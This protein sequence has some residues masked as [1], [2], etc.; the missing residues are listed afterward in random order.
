M[1]HVAAG[2]VGEGET[3]SRIAPG[4]V[5]LHRVLQAAGLP[6]DGHC[7]V[8]HGDHLAQAAGLALG[9]HQEQ[10]SAGVNGHG[11]RLVV[12]QAHR[13]PSLILLGGPAEKVLV[14]LIA[15][16][17]DHQLHGELHHIMKDLTNQVQSFV[18]HQTA[19][20]GHDGHIGLLPQ[21]HQLLQLRLVRLLAGH[22]L[23]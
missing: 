11:Q 12:I 1:Q 3:V 23:R 10:V 8:P 17:Q 2:I 16:A 21:A 5:G 4:L 22:I 13:H 15:L 14:L 7:T 20:N 6:D 9:G 18:G 19:D